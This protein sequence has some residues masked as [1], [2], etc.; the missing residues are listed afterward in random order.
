MFEF[1]TNSTGKIKFTFDKQVFGNELIDLDLKHPNAATPIKIFVFN[2]I[3]MR[4]LHKFKN[5]GE[6]VKDRKCNEYR[7]YEVFQIVFKNLPLVENE[8]IAFLFGDNEDDDEDDDDEE[9]EEEEEED[10]EDEDEKPKKS[11]IGNQYQIHPPEKYKIIVVFYA[12]AE[13]QTNAQGEIKFSFDDRVF[14]NPFVK[15]NLNDSTTVEVAVYVYGGQNNELRLLHPFKMFD[16]NRANERKLVRKVNYAHFE[17][18]RKYNEYRLHE[19][20]QIPFEQLPLVEEEEIDFQLDDDED[21]EGDDDDD[22][23]GDDD[24]ED[25]EEEEEEEEDKRKPK[26]KALGFWKKMFKKKRH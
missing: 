20:F 12:P 8:E 19:S 6:M 21:E 16:Y 11:S 9:E 22:D 17:M 2:G 26:K 1:Q 23:D 25:D 14:K 24:E 18:D 5:Y 3:E 13:F 15:Q 10:E 4:L 7:L